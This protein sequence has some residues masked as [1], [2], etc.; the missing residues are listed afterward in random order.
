LFFASVLQVIRPVKKL[1]NVQAI[2][3]QAL[4][5]SER[6]YDVLDTKPTVVEPAAP[7]TLALLPTRSS[8]TMSALIMKPAILCCATSI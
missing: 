7:L 2:V 8:L 6:I 5:A 3:Q 4:V 1:A